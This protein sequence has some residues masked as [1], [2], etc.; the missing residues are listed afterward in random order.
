V[1]AYI[2]ILKYCSELR[3]GTWAGGEDERSEGREMKGEK[4]EGG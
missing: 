1:R 2:E 4:V 3:D